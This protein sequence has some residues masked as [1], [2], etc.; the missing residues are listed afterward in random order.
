MLRF[1]I[2]RGTLESDPVTLQVT[3]SKAI[4]SEPA[5]VIHLDDVEGCTHEVSAITVNFT[6]SGQDR[7]VRRDG[8]KHVVKA[9]D[10]TLMW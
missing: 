4:F 7:L 2:Y 1:I 6:R 5:T 9:Y 8:E 3:D 10:C